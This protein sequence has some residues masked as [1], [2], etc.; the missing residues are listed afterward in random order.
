MGK[1]RRISNILMGAALIAAGLFLNFTEDGYLL[2]MI[3]LG[4]LLV[5]RGLVKLGYYLTM[6]RYMV[7]GKRI[8]FTAI[9]LLDLGGFTLTLA[10]IPR[11]FILLYLLTIY[12][13][14]GVIHLLRGIEAKRQ[15]SPAWR[16]SIVAGA[17]SIIIAALCIIFRGN[18][19]YVVWFF[20]AGII[21]S[22]V[23]RIV[24]SLRKTAIVYIQ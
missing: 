1:A 21:Y 8:L 18:N 11:V 12:A 7:G 22:G 3:F 19:K 14:S 24:N 4:L 20:S 23:I 15:Q 13:G 2:V 5:F 16:R 17:S 6:A 10:D 9:F